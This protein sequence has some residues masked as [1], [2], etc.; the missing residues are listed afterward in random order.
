MSG[1]PPGSLL[2]WTSSHPRGSSF[3]LRQRTRFRTRSSTTAVSTATPE[4]YCKQTH[5]HSWAAWKSW[6]TGDSQWTLDW[7]ILFSHQR[8]SWAGSASLSL[9]ARW[10][11]KQKTGSASVSRLSSRPDKTTVSLL[12]RFSIAETG[13]KGCNNVLDVDGLT[14]HPAG[15]GEAVAHGAALS[16]RR[17]DLLAV[18]QKLALH[19]VA[20][21]DAVVTHA[22]T[23]GLWFPDVVVLRGLKRSRP[24][25]DEKMKRPPRWRGKKHASFRLETAEMQPQVTVIT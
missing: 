16:L 21:G 8:P 24:V 7:R 11:L 22:D 17:D 12:E 18:W 2:S 1:I 25:T 5:L 19:L 9:Q 4:D 15:T 14:N 10:S 20:D 6:H 13:A 23:T 3:T